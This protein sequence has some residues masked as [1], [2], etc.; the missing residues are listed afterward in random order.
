MNQ[1]LAMDPTQALLL[2]EQCISV[3]TNDRAVGNLSKE[4][5]HLLGPDGQLPPLHRA[6]SVFLFN[7]KN[8]LLMQ[9]RSN[10]KIT[11]P[12][13][14][15]NSCCSH[16]LHN[17]TPD[18]AEE[19]HHVGIRR[20]ARRRLEIELGISPDSIEL[21]DFKI[22]TRIIYGAP[23]DAKWGEHE[24]DYILFL[25][26]DVPV[27]PNPNEVSR[28]VFVSLSGFQE[29]QGYLEK[30]NIPFTPWFKLILNSHLKVWWNQLDNLERIE[31][32]PVIHSL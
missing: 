31:Y 6:F 27:K 9:Q 25:R 28:V 22:L 11:F 2:Q 21:S 5:A 32:D 7:T 15:T 24:V 20:A 30:N 1:H 23:S 19:A 26:K 14:Y 29:F 13:Y 4:A 18:E 3:D 12:G 16:P 17:T 8:E 10:H